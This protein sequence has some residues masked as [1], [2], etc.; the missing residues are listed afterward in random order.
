MTCEC[1]YFPSLGGDDFSPATGELTFTAGIQ[2]EVLTFRVDILDDSDREGVEVFLAILTT[3]QSRIILL[4]DEFTVEI[5]DDD[6]K[7]EVV[8]CLSQSFSFTILDRNYGS[9]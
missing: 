9:I 4:P 8:T 5:G 1:H 7:T 2:S 3:N 6:G